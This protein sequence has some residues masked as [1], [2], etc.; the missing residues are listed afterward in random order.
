V[1]E[2]AWGDAGK[3]TIDGRGKLAP[4]RDTAA[5]FGIKLPEEVPMKQ[6]ERAWAMR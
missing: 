1:H 3:R 6:Q 4:V 5:R 2:V